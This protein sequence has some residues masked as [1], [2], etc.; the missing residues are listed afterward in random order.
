MTTSVTIETHCAPDK[1]VIVTVIG[2]DTEIVRKL[3]GEQTVKLYVYGDSE[4]T[5]KE[6]DK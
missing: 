5:V 1:E 3:H 4:V 6:V 2:Y